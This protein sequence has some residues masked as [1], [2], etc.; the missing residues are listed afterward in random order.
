MIDWRSRFYYSQYVHRPSAA[1]RESG[2]SEELTCSNRVQCR[3]CFL[4]EYQF[5]GMGSRRSIEYSS[6]LEVLLC[7]YPGESPPSIINKAPCLP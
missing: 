3:D 2:E 4:Q 6:I 7:E 5:P 1:G